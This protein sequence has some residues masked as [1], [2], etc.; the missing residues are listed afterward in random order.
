M[1]WTIRYYLGIT[2]AMQRVSMHLTETQLAWLKR[3]ARRL[4]LTVA[5]LLRRIVDAAREKPS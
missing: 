3:E 2:T 1:C 4:G 5:D